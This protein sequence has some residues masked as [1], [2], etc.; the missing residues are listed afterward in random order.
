MIS[1][2]VNLH[3]S[4]VLITCFNLEWYFLRIYLHSITPATRRENLSATTLHPEM[5]PWQG[6]L[7]EAWLTFIL[8]SVIQGATNIKRKGNIYMPTL[9]I[10]SYVSVAVMT[11]VCKSVFTCLINEQN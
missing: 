7:M 6:Y 3:K 9:I 2:L 4:Q 1:T 11:G 5:T 8:V 10:G